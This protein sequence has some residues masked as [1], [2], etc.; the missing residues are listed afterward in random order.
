[1]VVEELV[2]VATELVV[3]DDVVVIIPEALAPE[4]RTHRKDFPDRAHK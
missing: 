4:L 3:L 2:V 1:V